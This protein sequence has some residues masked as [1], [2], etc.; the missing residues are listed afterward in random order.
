LLCWSSLRI[1][2]GLFGSTI[3]TSASDPT[4]RVPFFG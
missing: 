2:N 1:V 4:S 3:T